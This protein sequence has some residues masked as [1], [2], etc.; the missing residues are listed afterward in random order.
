MNGE[1]EEVQE[2][3]VS[4]RYLVGVLAP[5]MRSKNPEEPV[6]EAPEQQD[7]LA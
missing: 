6:E 3:S 2:G 1:T 4:N 7:N 5:K